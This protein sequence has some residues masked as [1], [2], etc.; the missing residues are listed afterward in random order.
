MNWEK[1]RKQKIND[2]SKQNDQTFYARVIWIFR[3][4]FRFIHKNRFHR[5]HL[6]WKKHFNWVSTL[7]FYPKMRIIAFECDMLGINVSRKSTRFHFKHSSFHIMWIR[8]AS[9]SMLT[10]LPSLF[11][12]LNWTLNSEHTRKLIRESLL[13]SM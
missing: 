7:L 9:K 1:K 13:I 12:S 8:E 4:S 11:L 10:F 2:L 6:C 5:F 3:I